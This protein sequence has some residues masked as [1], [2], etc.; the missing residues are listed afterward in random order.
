M[1]IGLQSTLRILRKLDGKLLLMHFAGWGI[2]IAYEVSFVWFTVKAFAKFEDYVFYY[3]LNIAL[4][5]FNAHLVMSEGVKFKKSYLVIPFLLLTELFGYLTLKF[6]L[7]DFLVFPEHS[8]ITKIGYI[9]KLLVPNIYRG[10]SFIGFSTLYWS[11][12]R[13]IS[14]QKRVYKTE[15]MQLTTLKEKAEL[16][17]NLAEAMNAYLQ[18]QINPHL[19][20][21]T[22]S[23]IHNTYYKQSREASQCVLLLVDIMRF[24]LE[25]LKINGKTYIDKE[26]D[27]IRN[28]IELNQ[29]RYDYALYIDFRT[30]GDIEHHQII[31]L[32]LLTLTENIFKHG[33][34]KEEEFEAKIHIT[35][36]DQNE[37]IFHSWNLKG[38]QTEKRRRRSI[39]IKNV[40]KR[41]E[42]SYKDQYSLIISDEVDSY[43][44]ELRMQL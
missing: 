23:F 42:Y 34:L 32:I 25:E 1:T 13:V 14:F 26:V 37:L 18:Q 33:Y 4:F 17:R 41:L 2:F 8:A 29:L 40:I 21:N 12:L 11:I 19:L 22:L 3:G 24:S 10:I 39:G 35:V 36:T 6:L 43:G 5:Y 9:K 27:Q 28:Y 20:F 15:T 7:D 44:L 30:E 31:P 16:E 38:H